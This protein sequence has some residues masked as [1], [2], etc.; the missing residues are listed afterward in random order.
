RYLARDDAAYVVL[1]VDGVDRRHP[2]GAGPQLEISAVAPAADAVA[3]PPG[4]EHARRRARD[5]QRRLERPEVATAGRV[6]HDAAA[7]RGRRDVRLRGIE[8][9]PAADAHRAAERDVCR[10]TQQHAH[11]GRSVELA[12]LRSGVVVAQ[13]DAVV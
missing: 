11:L 12:D 4:D 2:E 9:A 6:Q 3:G 5:A 7:E 10:V 13:D 1:E 8:R